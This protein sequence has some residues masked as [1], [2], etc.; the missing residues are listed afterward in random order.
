MKKNYIP[1]IAIAF[2]VAVISTVAFYGIFAGR[3]SAGAAVATS[4]VLVAA[5]DLARGSQLTP[6]DVRRA[7]WPSHQVPKGSLSDPEQVKDLTLIEPVAAHEPLT[8]SRVA[9][10]SSGE[11]AGLGIPAGKRAVSVHVTDSS[12]VVGLLRAGHRVDIQ[13]VRVREGGGETELRTILENVPVLLVGP[14]EVTPGRPALPVVT[15]LATPAEADML[16]LAD[17][18]ARI[19]L[20][21]RNP[22]DEQRG[23]RTTLALP[24]LMS[25]AGTESAS[26][27]PANSQP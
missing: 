11:G 21:L 15:L 5:R 18:A 3:L 27:P 23:T 2:V 7:S 10:P 14:A 19:R 8:R 26:R 17:A 6:A 25:G 24:R 20:V 13:V 12:G 16:A 22:L 9:S 4:P 1:L